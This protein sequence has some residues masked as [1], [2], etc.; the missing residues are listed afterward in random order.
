MVPKGKDDFHIVVDYREANKAIVREPYPMPTLDRI[1]T[2]IPKGTGELFFTKLDLSD[3][4]FHVELHEDVR[5]YTS[6]M[7]ASGLM[8]F[9]RLPFGLSCAP[10]IFQKVME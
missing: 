6:F 10:E 4:F 8:R 7:T 1:W 2:D 3:A 9:K 5:H